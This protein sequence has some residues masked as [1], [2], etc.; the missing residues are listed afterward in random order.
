MTKRKSQRQAVAEALWAD[1]VDI[2]E[3]QPGAHSDRHGKIKV[4]TDGNWYYIALLNDGSRVPVV[5]G[6]EHATWVPNGAAILNTH[7]CYRTDGTIG[8]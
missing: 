5:R 4:F 3:Y 1:L 2:D 7:V 6:F 8:E